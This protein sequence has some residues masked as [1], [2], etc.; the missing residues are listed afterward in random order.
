MFPFEARCREL[1]ESCKNTS[2][3]P[4]PGHTGEY[5]VRYDKPTNAFEKERFQREV[6]M[7]LLLLPVV[8]S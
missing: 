7:G 6:L 1:E 2:K 8:G 5:V 4:L 3:V